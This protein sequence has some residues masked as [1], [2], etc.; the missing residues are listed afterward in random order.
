MLP[1]HNP[2]GMSGSNGSHGQ[3]ILFLHC[4]RNEGEHGI[5]WDTL[6][7]LSKY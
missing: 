4:G 3:V 6:P 5:E 2:N 1:H 7:R